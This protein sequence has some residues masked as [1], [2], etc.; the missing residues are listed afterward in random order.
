MA[1]RPYN[2]SWFVPE[3]LAGMGY[4]RAKGNLEFL[5]EKKIEV[6]INYH[7]KDESSY[8]DDP[9][10]FGISV[11]KMYIKDWGAPSLEQVMKLQMICLTCFYAL[12]FR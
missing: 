8:F 6:L 7:D 3:V 12:F 1:K 9:K 10:K 5:K 4:P 2:F 11:I